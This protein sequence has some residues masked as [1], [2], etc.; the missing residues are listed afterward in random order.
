MLKKSKETFSHDISR[1]IED[2]ESGTLD[3]V[4]MSPLSIVHVR[5]DFEVI[6]GARVSSE[7][8]GKA[9]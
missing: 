5:Q 2:V 6:R 7:N 8:Y 1:S 4:P 9:F 3:D